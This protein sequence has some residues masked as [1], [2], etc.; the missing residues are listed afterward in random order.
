MIDFLSDN[1]IIIVCL[2]VGVILGLFAGKIYK[3]KNSKLQSDEA[4]TIPVQNW[5]D[6]DITD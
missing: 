1:W 6:I 4:E 2:L 5:S 3:K